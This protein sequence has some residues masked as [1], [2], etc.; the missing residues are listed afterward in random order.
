RPCQSRFYGMR[1]RGTIAAWIA[2]VATMAIAAPNAQASPQK[3]TVLP[4][5]YSADNCF[6]F[7]TGGALL[8]DWKPYM[9]FLNKWSPASQLRPDDTLAF[10]TA[11]VNDANVQLQI[12]L[13]PTTSNGSDIEAAPFTQVVSNT[14]L[15]ANP[16]GDSVVGDFEMRFRVEAPFSF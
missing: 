6:P 13:A 16:R 3:V 4:Q 9:A 5:I 2:A 14:Q 11:E 7:G 8:E 12:D 1:K 10:D 15:P